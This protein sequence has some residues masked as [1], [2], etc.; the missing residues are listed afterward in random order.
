VAIEPG[1]YPVYFEMINYL[2][3]KWH[4]S[5]EE[6]LKFVEESADS[7]RHLYG[8]G[9][10][11]LL[12]NARVDNSNKLFIENGGEFS[13]P[14]T[15]AGF[16]DILVKYGKSSY[17]LHRYGYL[18]MLAGD[19]KAFAEVLNETGTKWDESKDKY[20]KKKTWYEYHLNKSKAYLN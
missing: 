19:H 17:I 6:M 8:D 1:Y 14:R 15:K 9:M 16:R 20:Y 10:Y 5:S 7:T 11:S 12:V 13:W 4:G 2:Q 18:A 3:P